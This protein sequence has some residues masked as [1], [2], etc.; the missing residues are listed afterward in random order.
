VRHEPFVQGAPALL[1]APFRLEIDV[2]V[3]ARSL[4]DPGRRK[5]GKPAASGARGRR[6]ARLEWRWLTPRSSTVCADAPGFTR[7]AQG[8][9]CPI[10]P[11]H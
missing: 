2:A 3:Q 4:P 9:G 8:H 1:A 10:Y 7:L 6:V 5:E 11:V